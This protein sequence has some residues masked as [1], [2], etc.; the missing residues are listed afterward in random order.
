MRRTQRQ[1]SASAK[2]A[3]SMES[4]SGAEYQTHPSLDGEG[5]ISAKKVAMVQD[6]VFVCA[7]AVDTSKLLRASRVSLMEL[8]EEIGA[9]VLVDERWTCNV[10]IPRHR[11]GTYRVHVKYYASAARSQRRDP[12]RPVA[13]TQAKGVPGLMTIIERQ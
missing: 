8:A 12:G 4:S 3:H 2:A 13:L 6:D 7:D 9:N 1:A 10:S 5:V 11:D